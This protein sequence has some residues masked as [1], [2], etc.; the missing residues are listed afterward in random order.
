[1]TLE[2]RA[3]AL[4]ALVEGDQCEKCGAVLE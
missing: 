1:M 2:R 4:L 3:E